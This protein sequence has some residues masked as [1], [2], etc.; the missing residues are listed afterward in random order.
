MLATM[1]EEPSSMRL[2]L[3]VLCS[4]VIGAVVSLY[5]YT[6]LF[7]Q[8]LTTD[9]VVT[10]LL[11]LMDQENR[12]AVR[13]ASV[14]GETR[15]DFLANGNI[16]VLS[17]RVNRDNRSGLIAFMGDQNRGI[18]GIQVR[19]NSESTFF[20]GDS[21]MEGRVLLGATG[22]DAG[23]DTEMWGMRVQSYKAGHVTIGVDN[24]KFA[25]SRG[26]YLGYQRAD[27]KGAALKP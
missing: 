21:G 15:M 12:P 13:M 5:L 18:A 1:G 10:K 4:S 25:P 3:T 19:P 14:N 24:D 2:F 17:L 22:N 7:A 20:L 27:G 9:P 6:R 8:P 16:P 11:V 23:E 26:P